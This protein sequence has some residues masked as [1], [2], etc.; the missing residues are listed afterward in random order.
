VTISSIAFVSIRM[1]KLSRIE[2]GERNHV[3]LRPIAEMRC[4]AA[5]RPISGVHLPRLAI[6]ARPPAATP[7]AT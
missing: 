7:E 6:I 5:S 1:T 4:I 3:R 2:H